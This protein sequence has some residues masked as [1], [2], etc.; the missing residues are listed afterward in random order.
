MAKIDIPFTLPK[1]YLNPE[2]IEKI[3]Y[4]YIKAKLTEDNRILHAEALVE[5]VKALE[6]AKIKPPKE[7]MKYIEER[8]KKLRILVKKALG[9]LRK[10]G[11]NE[12]D[13]QS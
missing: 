10:L 13:I 1:M 3:K 8:V 2:E 6:E 7:L 12:L 4:Y 9:D 5:L 11:F